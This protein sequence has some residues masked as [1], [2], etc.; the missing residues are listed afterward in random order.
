MTRTKQTQNRSWI[1]QHG[2]TKYAHYLMD[3]EILTISF[4][5]I[6]FID[7]ILVCLGHSF[8][9]CS[10]WWELYSSTCTNSVLAVGFSP[11][12]LCLH[13]IHTSRATK[14][15]ENLFSNDIWGKRCVAILR[16]QLQLTRLNNIPCK[17][18]SSAT[19]WESHLANIRENSWYMPVEG[20]ISPPSQVRAPYF[21]PPAN[22]KA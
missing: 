6:N 5:A 13:S 20:L 2:F 11:L 19:G 15:S 7:S 14:T 9:I 4:S 3:S 12:C 1:I 16:W 21:F 18:G 22:I 17:T 8:T 10:P